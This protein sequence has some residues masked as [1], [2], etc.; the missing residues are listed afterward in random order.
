MRISNL[1][2]YVPVKGFPVNAFEDSIGASDIF[3]L[4][5]VLS[6]ANAKRDVL[7]DWLV[8]RYYRHTHEPWPG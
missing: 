2:S 1:A 8:G 5:A 4:W 6:E 3:Y 7:S